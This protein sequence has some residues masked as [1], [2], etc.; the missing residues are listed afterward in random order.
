MKLVIS[1]VHDVGTG[2]NSLP[3]SHA[4]IVGSRA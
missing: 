1:F 3:V 2:L 4:S